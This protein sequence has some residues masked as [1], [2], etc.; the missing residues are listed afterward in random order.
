[1][2]ARRDSGLRRVRGAKLRDLSGADHRGAA[3]KPVVKSVRDYWETGN[4]AL[5]EYLLERALVLIFNSPLHRE[6]FPHAISAP[7]AFCPPPIPVE[8]FIGRSEEREG[9]CWIGRMYPEKGVLNAMRWSGQNKTQTDFYGTG[10][11]R[12]GK[13]AYVQYCGPASYDLVP[14]ILAQ[15]ETFVFLPN[16]VEPFGRT[17][18]EA[19]LSGCKLEVNE[20]IGALWWIEHEPQTIYTAAERWWEIVRYYLHD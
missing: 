15:H 5:R 14:V 10:P 4:A 8:R 16:W 17:V 9:A 7:V 6:H 2:P 18:A 19:W 11:F 3:N 12:P 20:R 13:A 1:M